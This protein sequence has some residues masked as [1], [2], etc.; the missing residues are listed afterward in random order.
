[1]LRLASG[2]SRRFFDAPPSAPLGADGGSGSVRSG[3]RDAASRW[4]ALLAALLLP[5]VARPVRAEP[6]PG[7]GLDFATFAAQTA[8]TRETARIAVL[9]VLIGDQDRLPVSAVFAGVERAAGARPLRPMSVDDYFFQDGRELSARALG[10]GEDTACLAD[11]F[12]VFRAAYGL[13]VIANAELSPPLLSLV[14]VDTEKRTVLGEQ[15][16]ALGDGPLEAQVDAAA[17][18]LFDAAGLLR[19]GFLELL[20]EPGDATVKV[21]D[22]RAPD[23][24]SSHR[25][26]LA[27]GRIKV[28][29]EADGHGSAER[30]V[31]ILPGEVTRIELNL[32]RESSIF[33]SPFFWGGVAALVAAGGVAGVLLVEQ[34][35][36]GGC[37]CVVAGPDEECVT[38]R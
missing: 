14:L 27:P 28:R 10:C 30:E 4:T 31:D 23:L 38:C 29:A 34:S 6:L 17:G 36:S 5:L 2:S 7:L 9:P 16:D 15:F 33:E 35:Q 37:L 12:A 22:G 24:G 1:M 3:H 11:T 32:E 25:Y 19:A 8:P 13:V 20:V 26:T 18:R 21:A